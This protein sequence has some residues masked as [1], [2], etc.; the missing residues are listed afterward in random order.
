MERLITVKGVSNISVKPDLIIIT[1]N[2]VSEKYD[3]DEQRLVE[4]GEYQF[5]S[6]GAVNALDLIAKVCGYNVIKQEI[7]A[8][9]KES[10]LDKLADELYGNE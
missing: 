1:M 10:R 4:T 2:V 6:K 3:Y 5:D 7:T 8:E 9:V